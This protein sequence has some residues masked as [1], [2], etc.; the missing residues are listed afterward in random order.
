[1]RTIICALLTAMLVTAATN[2]VTLDKGQRASLQLWL[3]QHRDYRVATDADCDCADDLKTFRTTSDGVWKAKPDFQPY[4]AK[5]D[6]RKNGQSDFAVVVVPRA[7]GKGLKNLL[8][9]FDGPFP[10]D[11]KPPVY[12]TDV[13]EL[14]GSGLILPPFSPWPVFGHYFSEGCVFKP[15]GKTYRQDCSAD[16]F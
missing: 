14:A 9:I 12:T 3:G 1:M 15:A 5:G 16:D 7:K 2:A 8:L 6:F 11:G 4:L 10:A 13:S